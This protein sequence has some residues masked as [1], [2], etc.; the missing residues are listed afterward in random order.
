[1]CRI[2]ASSA[3]ARCSS[4]DKCSGLA[5]TAL[6]QYQRLHKKRSNLGA[7]HMMKVIVKESEGVLGV[8]VERL[9]RAAALAIEGGQEQIT[10]ELFQ[11]ARFEIPGTDLSGETA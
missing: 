1:M 5:G 3:P 6:S 4:S 11:R 10:A 2:L 9:Q 8:I 7:L